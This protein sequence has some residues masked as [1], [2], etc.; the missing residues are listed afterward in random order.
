MDYSVTDALLLA[1]APGAVPRSPSASPLW[2]GAPKGEPRAASQ[3]GSQHHSSLG[4]SRAGRSWNFPLLENS[5]HTGALLFASAPPSAF[6]GAVSP[7]NSC[8]DSHRPLCSPKHPRRA[9]SRYHPLLPALP[10]PPDPALLLCPGRRRRMEVAEP[11][12]ACRGTSLFLCYS[13]ILHLRQR[14]W[15]KVT[16]CNSG[17]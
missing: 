15:A 11:G 3:A 13:G 10:S 9:L 4:A 14:N 17:F 2:E 16:V 12:Q 6:P 8:W 7:P 5:T 1:S